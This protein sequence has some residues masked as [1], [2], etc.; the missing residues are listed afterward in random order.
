M[1]KKMFC[2][3]GLIL[4]LLLIPVIYIAGG[5]TI[6]YTGIALFYPTPESPTVTYGEFP[7]ELVYEIDGKT[8]IVNDVYVCEY[9]GIKLNASYKYRSW[10]GYI[11]STGKEYVYLCEDADRIVYCFVGDAEY[12]MNDEE[13]PEQRPLTPRV[14]DLKFD[15]SDYSGPE[16]FSSEEIMEYYNIKLISWK[17]SDPIENTF[18]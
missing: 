10:R 7:F 15:T 16:F 13:Y 6:F 9:D 12:Y 8:I 1:T 4:S 17:L 11:K 14:Y 3:I 5:W 2:L 18:Q